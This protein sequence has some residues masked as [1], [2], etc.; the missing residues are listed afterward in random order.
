MT[1]QWHQHLVKK[2]MRKYEESIIN[3]E[4]LVTELKLGPKPHVKPGLPKS[5]CKAISKLT[6]QGRLVTVL[7]FLM[8]EDMCTSH[9]G[10]PVGS[11]VNSQKRGDV[12]R[13]SCNSRYQLVSHLQDSDEAR[14]ISTGDV[15][16]NVRR[17]REEGFPHSQQEGN[18]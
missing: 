8:N 1:I 18:R 16:G 3:Y 7:L 14:G 2:H 6:A 15:P 11:G 5:I 12:V 13:S 4:N 10:G 9:M 17:E